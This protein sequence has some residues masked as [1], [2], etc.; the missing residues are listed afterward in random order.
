MVIVCVVW[1][2][3][4]VD[5]KRSNIRVRELNNGVLQNQ[6]NSIVLYKSIPAFIKASD[7]CLIFMSDWCVD[8][9]HLFL[10]FQFQSRRLCEDS[11]CLVI[12]Y[13]HMA[14]QAP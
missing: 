13:S 9:S 2:E 1:S 12:D 6:L 3:D 5:L 14:R 7:Y 10:Q 8:N 4:I 11:I